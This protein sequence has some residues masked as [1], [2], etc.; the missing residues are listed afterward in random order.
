MKGVSDV[1]EFVDPALVPKGAVRVA[2]FDGENADPANGRAMGDGVLAHTP[3]GE[4]AFALAG[5]A[6]WERVRKSDED[7]MAPGAE[8][9]ANC[10]AANP[11]S[12][13]STNSPSICGRPASAAEASSRRS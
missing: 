9:C 3:W 12:P 13:C 1:A 4:I 6:G 5:K 8:T 10:S 11:R 2:A 7:R